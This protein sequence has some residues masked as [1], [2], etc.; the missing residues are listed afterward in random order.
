[1]RVL[2]GR[3]SLGEAEAAIA[4]IVG[5]WKETPDVLFV[6]SS[7]RQDPTG[8]VDAL[9]ARF[10]ETPIAGCTTAGEHLD[11]E[12]GNGSLVVSGLVDS[13]ITWAT[14]RVDGVATF[15]AARARGLAS[16]LFED[17]GADLAGDFDPDQ[18]FGLLFIDGLCCVEE[19]V[20]A[21]LAEA[22]EGV[23]V[24][25]GSAGDD[26]EFRRT[27]VLHRSGAAT[28]AAVVLLGRAD[29]TRVH[30]RKHQHFAP[31]PRAL[32]VTRADV[33]RRIVHE[34]DGYPAVEAYAAALGVRVEEVTS[35]SAL[36]HPV[37]FR[38]RG[39]TYVRSIQGVERDGSLR[40]YCAV[41]EG[42]VLEI[43]RHEDLVGALRTDLGRPDAP[44][45][46][47]LGF[48]CILR[49]LEARD[50]CAHGPLAEVVRGASRASVGFDTYGEQLDG[51]HINQT[52]VAVTFH[53]PEGGG[54]HVG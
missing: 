17:L 47:L 24:A 46:F 11:G 40:F 6:F 41:E 13:G 4:E 5:G 14:A 26:L 32:V 8:V 3:S 30:F 44:A 39:E 19:R 20:A 50:A 9:R 21:C 36:L 35:A 10:P 29:R 16:R 34:F 52:L 42:M 28:D 37:T 33:P 54:P 38:W 18:Y 53:D 7:T 22:L 45:D 12:H 43:A 2:G 49:S 51:L 48:H 1:M 23:R 31:T 15:D 25:G 27:W